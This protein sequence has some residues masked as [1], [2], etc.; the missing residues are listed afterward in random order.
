MI[1]KS[2]YLLSLTPFGFDEIAKYFVKNENMVAF[3]I[4]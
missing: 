3:V 2:I 1:Y 4:T